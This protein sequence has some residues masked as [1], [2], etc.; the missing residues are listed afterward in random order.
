MNQSTIIKS[1][2]E[3]DLDIAFNAFLNDPLMSADLS[4]ATELYSEMLAAVRKH[5]IYYC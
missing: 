2:L 3:K 1:V 4:S 5:L